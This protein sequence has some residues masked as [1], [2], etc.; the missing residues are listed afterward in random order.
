M[1]LLLKAVKNKFKYLYLEIA[2]ICKNYYNYKKAYIANGI[3]GVVFKIRKCQT[4]FSQ[5][6]S[7]S[8]KLLFYKDR[9]FSIN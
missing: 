1:D 5:S 4:I 8:Q 3:Y 7:Q 2:L 6:Q 9:S